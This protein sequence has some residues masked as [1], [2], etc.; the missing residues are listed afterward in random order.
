MKKES[1]I[2]T[3]FLLLV[4]AVA[5][6]M[7]LTVIRDAFERLYVLKMSEVLFTLLVLFVGFV[8]N[9]VIMELAHVLG[10]KI[11]K[12]KVVSVNCYFLCLKKTK[13]GWKFGVDDFDGL[14]G[15]TKILK[16]EKSKLNAYVWMPIVFYA[17]ELAACILLYSMGNG[18]TDVSSLKWLAIAALLWIILSSILFVYDF[19]PFKLDT[20]NDGYRL[21]LLTKPDD[22]KALLDYMDYQGKI[23]Y[24][25]EQNTLTFNEKMTDFTVEMNLVV[26]E[27]EILSRK[28]NEALEM[29]LKIKQSQSKIN[30]YLLKKV[31]SQ[32]MFVRL[33][34]KPLEEVKKY[35]KE[36]VNDND[37]KFI[38]NDGNID[39]VRA[40]SLIAGLI[41]DSPF[42][43]QYALSKKEKAIKR[44]PKH[45]VDSENK[46]FEDVVKKIYEKHPEWNSKEKDIA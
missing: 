29:L 30:P 22:A 16:T 33:M 1:V 44:C 46:L 38:S 28:Y 42:E 20:F 21:S 8:F 36:N 13:E 45:L 6:I 24:G 14:T 12:C 23:S 43:V 9:I 5:I 32:D 39:S 2:S 4:L 3:G 18:A 40:Y 34:T 15:E 19:I 37:G 17:A 7:G 31:T 26:I 10:A 27:N 25:D 41:D 11:G 35:Y